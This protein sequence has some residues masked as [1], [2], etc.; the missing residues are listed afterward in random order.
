MANRDV[1][2]RRD[3]GF[4]NRL[5][6][7]DE[8]VL[9][10]IDRAYSSNLRQLLRRNRGSAL[11]NYDIDGIVYQSL[12]ETWNRYRKGEGSTVR[13]FYFRVAKCRLQDRLRQIH[14]EQRV[15][16]EHLPA[17]AIQENRNDFDPAHRLLTRETNQAYGRIMILISNAL[18]ELTDRQRT[19]FKKRF[20]PGRA[21]NWA[22]QLE[23]ETKITA[24]QW[25]KASHQAKEH[26]KKYLIR[27][28]VH[29]SQEG[30]CYEVA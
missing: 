3:K 27:H 15:T 4:A 2:E 23:G 13:G 16:T 14:R 8:S 12:Y 10:E 24:K 17:L 9:A 11:N 25:R 21:S 28:G 29:Y 26:I 6:K 1:L 30:G 5:A 19:A 20:A 18:A 22:Q 7:R